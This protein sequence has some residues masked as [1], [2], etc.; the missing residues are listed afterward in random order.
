MS[1]LL[2]VLQSELRSLSVEAQQK[3]FPAIKDAAD[4]GVRQLRSIQEKMEEQ[5]ISSDQVIQLIKGNNED[6][7]KPFLIACESKTTKLI[8]TALSSLHQLLLY[9]A[10]PELV[11]AIFTAREGYELN[12]ITLSKL[13]KLCYSLEGSKSLNVDMTAKATLRQATISIFE[14]LKPKI[15]PETNEELERSIDEESNQFKNAFLY[16]N[17]LCATIQGET[18][19]WLGISN[20]DINFILELVDSVLSHYGKYFTTFDLFKNIISQRMTPFLLTNISNISNGSST[21]FSLMLRVYK[22]LSSVINSFGLVLHFET[23][24]LVICDHL[25]DVIEKSS[26]QCNKVLALEVLKSIFYDYEL[27]I[28]IHKSLPSSSENGELNI[29]GHIITKLSSAVTT[30]VQQLL[31]Y[32]TSATPGTPTDPMSAEKNTQPI[33]TGSSSLSAKLSNFDL[34][35]KQ[36]SR[37]D[38]LV[39]KT[40]YSPSLGESIGACLECITGLITSLSIMSGIQKPTGP[41]KKNQVDEDTEESLEKKK[42]CSIFVNLVWA[43][44]LTLLYILLEV[45]EGDEN[46][47]SILR[48]Y[49]LF[50]HTC[51]ITGLSAPRDAFLTNLCKFTPKIKLSRRTYSSSNL[52]NTSDLFY[53]TYEPV[54]ANSAN[55]PTDVTMKMDDL[56]RKSVLVMKI[57]FNIAHC[58]GG[59]LG[60][61]WYLLLKNFLVIDKLLNQ[62][63]PFTSAPESEQEDLNILFAALQNLFMSTSHLSDESVLVMLKSLCRLSQDTTNNALLGESRLFAAQKILETVQ[64]NMNRVEKTWP[65][66]SSHILWLVENENE[67]TRKSSINFVYEVIISMYRPENNKYSVRFGN[68]DGELE[69]NEI[70][71]P[72]LERIVFTI[73]MDIFQSSCD[74]METREQLLT[75]LNSLI[76]KCGHKLTTAWTVLLPLLKECAALPTSKKKSAN[77]TVNRAKL[78]PLGFKCVQSIASKEYL[79]T[80]G[81]ECLTEFFTVISAYVK[82]RDA[83]DLNLSFVAINLF[84]SSAEFLTDRYP[85]VKNQ[86]TYKDDKEAGENEGD[87]SRVDELWLTLY[88]QLR[89]ATVDSRPDV[90]NSSLKILSF[91]MVS[92]G[93]QL[94][95]KTWEKCIS[96]ILLKILDMTHEAATSA[97]TSL[98]DFE[99]PTAGKDAQIESDDSKKKKKQIVVHHTRNT[100]AKQWSETRALVIDFVSRVVCEHGKT[101]LSEIPLFVDKAC[102]DITLFIHKSVLSKTSEIAMTAVKNLYDMISCTRGKIK[103]NLWKGA[104]EIWHTLADFSKYVTNDKKESFVNV[105]TITQLLDGIGKLY[106]QQQNGGESIFTQEDIRNVINYLIDQFLVCPA[107]VN[108]IIFPSAVQ[109]SCMDLVCKISSFSDETREYIFDILSNHLPSKNSIRKGQIETPVKYAVLLQKTLLECCCLQAPTAVRQKLFKQTIQLLGD[110]IQTKFVKQSNQKSYFLWKSS[111]KGLENVVKACVISPEDSFVKDVDEETW[112]DLCIAIEEFLF[113]ESYIE[114]TDED[115][116]YEDSSSEEDNAETEEET[117]ESILLTELISKFVL[118]HIDATTVK[119][120]LLMILEK[121]T[122]LAPKKVAKHSLKTLFYFVSNATQKLENVSSKEEDLTETERNEVDLGRFVL[123]ILFKRCK[124]ILNQFIQDDKRSGNCPLPKHRRQELYNTLIE[125]KSIRVNPLLYSELNKLSELSENQ[126]LALNGYQGLVVRLFPVLCEFISYNSNK[127]SISAV[128]LEMFKIVSK[129]LGIGEAHLLIDSD[130]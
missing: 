26:N 57:L 111:I 120:R 14:F 67:H 110:M 10:V 63:M 86:D 73:F 53:T 124:S 85:K 3:K 101:I 60:S 9:G 64:V 81:F 18:G 89:E 102:N 28:H 17:D 76:G 13:L 68:K 49:L 105:D 74:Y 88:E 7:V 34:T 48:N 79:P 112:K 43:P 82:Q 94:I 100:A 107:A 97:E 42:I 75:T 99:L 130:E 54:V 39:D 46:I 77:S 118:V 51:G 4:R 119:K 98:E 35:Q 122:H 96:D 2:K 29:D 91:V 115:E 32:N 109:R 108:V 1:S 90:R 40:T 103:Q 129:E 58:L 24:T 6:I 127:E 78:I 95:K 12:Q 69:S 15:N 65:L 45:C 50:T 83:S 23:F 47:Q 56:N 84:M 27:L 5:G 59:L 128:L 30:Y 104:W 21:N 113:H 38:I 62:R 123:P 31:N 19:E 121:A 22:L 106:E 72:D 8:V 44:T 87:L 25:R 20:I 11:L 66:F 52:S 92:Q 41:I 37:L 126:S 55:S 33:N 116:E 117:D 36:T 114:S 61:S 93:D 70:V 80:L 16:F 71:S 125:L